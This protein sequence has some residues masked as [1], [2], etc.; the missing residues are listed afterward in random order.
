MYE[1]LAGAPPFDA[2]TP[3]GVIGKHLTQSP[4][5][6]PKELN[7][8]PALEQV[9]MR[10][11]AK[12][13][14]VRPADASNFARELS[15]A[16]RLERERLAEEAR[17][18]ERRKLEAETLR[19]AEAA[20]RA[21]AEEQA[22]VRR[23]PFPPRPSRLRP[24]LLR[25]R[26]ESATRSMPLCRAFPVYLRGRLRFPI[27]IKLSALVARNSMPRSARLQLSACLL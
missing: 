5:P 25:H 2:N 7:V 14:D 18:E 21:E 12:E 20:R 3:T 10:A 24:S 13:A 27:H 17:A 19:L 22:S 4:P 16:E 26:S 11:L 23:A 1:M 8:P 15:E 9:V 6:F